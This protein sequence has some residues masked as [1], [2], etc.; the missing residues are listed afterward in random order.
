MKVITDRIILSESYDNANGRFR[1]KLKTFGQK[2]KEFG[3]EAGKDLLGGVL[4]KSTPQPTP[5]VEV[6]VTPPP[7]PPKKGMSK[8]LKI[9]LIV[10]G[11]LLVLTIIGVVIYKSKKS[12]GK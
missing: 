5:P 3:G 11:S 2:V 1:D 4:G 8:G 9:G 7:P 6:N 10:G 12:K